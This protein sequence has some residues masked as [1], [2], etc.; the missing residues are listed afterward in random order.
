MRKKQFLLIFIT[1]FV[2][3]T[4]IVAVKYRGKLKKIILGNKPKSYKELAIEYK[5]EYKKLNIDYKKRIIDYNP[6]GSYFN[7]GTTISYKNP[8]MLKFDKDG[9]PE[10]VIGKK[11]Y[12]NPVSFEQYCLYI[13]D[14]YL[15]SNDEELKNR[16]IFLADKLISL[17]SE[18]GSFRYNYTWQ[19]YLNNKEFKPGWVS[20]MA[21]GQ[22]LSVFARAYY[23]TKDKKYLDAGEKSINFLIKPISEGGC[24]DTLKDLRIL[25]PELRKNIIF[26][27]YI[28]NPSSYTLNGFMFILVG[29]YDWTQLSINNPS[30]Q[31]AQNYFQKGITTLKIILPY[32]DLGGFTSYDLAHITYGT[33]PRSATNYHAIHI[34][35]LHALGKVTGENTLKQYEK[36]W[37]SYI[38]D[39]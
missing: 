11:L 4:T 7:F 31:V 23:I 30:K 15:K 27:E 28:A 26:E 12:Y 16:F 35:L 29:L 37:I 21:Q 13:H 5:E 36:K 2:C 9:A 22:A 25:K 32:Y 24:M 17:Q 3:I 33:Q 10:I 38:K 8:Y 19:Y 6:F 20:G 34:E 14:K 1:L 18:D 39:L